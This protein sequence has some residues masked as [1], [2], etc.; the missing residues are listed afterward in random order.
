MNRY[1]NP[2]FSR[3]NTLGHRAR[4][5]PKKPA[6]A[7]LLEQFAP[8]V[9]AIIRTRLSSSDPEQQWE[10]A[11]A[12]LPYLWSRKAPSVAPPETERPPTLAEYLAAQKRPAGEA[13]TE[14]KTGNGT[15][16]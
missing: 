1:G 13:A 9:L 11:Q 16:Q 2:L 6:V 4:G 5:I 7:R 3:G 15:L 10:T 12:L 14:P 8:D